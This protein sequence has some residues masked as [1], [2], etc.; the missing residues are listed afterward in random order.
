MRAKLAASV[1]SAN[2]PASASNID[3]INAPHPRAVRA[4]HAGTFAV[5][6]A[7]MQLAGVL[8]LG[9]HDVVA[10]PVARAAYVALTARAPDGRLGLAMGA[11]TRGRPAVDA[12]R[13]RPQASPQARHRRVPAAAMAC[14]DE[15]AHEQHHADEDD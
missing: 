5:A 8:E 15:L 2:S 6:R 14:P 10:V 1:A 9:A 4:W 7:S 12:H 3:G 13:G 11:A